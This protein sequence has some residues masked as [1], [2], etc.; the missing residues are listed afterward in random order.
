MLDNKLNEVRTNVGMSISE[1]ARR[2]KISRQTIYSIEK[3]ERENISTLTMLSI[4]KAL[5]KNVSDI[6]FVDTV[7]RVEQKSV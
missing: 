7:Q 2:S 1:L 5:N 4:A 3:S 6:F